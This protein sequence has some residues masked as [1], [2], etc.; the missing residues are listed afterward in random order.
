MAPSRIRKAIGAVKDHTSIG[1]AKVRSGSSS[2]AALE[3]AVVKATRHKEQPP[4]DRHISEILSLT[5]YSHTLVSACL[6]IIARRLD[7]T[8]N[9][10]VALK[11][12][13]LV[14]CLL[15]NGGRPYEQEIFFYT[16]CG[17]RYLNMSGFRDA[18]TSSYG[19]SCDYSKFVRKYALYLDELLEFRMQGWRG[20]HGGRATSGEMVIAGSTPVCDMKIESLFSRARH[21]K[22]L[23]E[24]FLACRPTGAAKNN[25][26][27][28]VALYP[29]V[30]ESF[31]LYCDVMEII[32]ILTDRFMQ[33]DVPDMVRVH[34]TFF[35]MSK[36]LDE[37]DEFYDW[38]KTVRVVRSSECPRLEK[39]SQKK[40]QT[41][42]DFIQQKS[43]MLRNRRARSPNPKPVPEP[44]LEEEMVKDL[45]LVP[46]EGFVED[47]KG[48]ELDE[49][50]E[51]GDL[52]NLGEDLTSTGDELA[53]AFL[54]DAGILEMIT[55]TTKPWEAFKD[56]SDWE[57]ELVQSASRWSN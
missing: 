7:R 25:R 35:C 33:L 31:Q 42:N 50:T 53:L 32:G 12:L 38:C 8:K 27:V 57:T 20:E 51:I 19:K 47:E 36:Q 48:N 9:W 15:A 24:R 41:M 10:V 49:K 17:T 30:K 26:V 55:M 39:I 28:V 2:I 3:V 13:V 56:S 54:D 18:S 43:A 46:S 22:Q 23:L 4:E 11:A 34:E 37:L 44:E 40:L 21:L 52:L 45:L 29:I 1:L 16:R 6:A 14:P 5:S